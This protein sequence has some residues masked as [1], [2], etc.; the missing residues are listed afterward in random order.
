MNDVTN[1][2]FKSGQSYKGVIGYKIYKDIDD[3]YASHY[4]DGEF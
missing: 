1:F 3:T 4:G 2:A